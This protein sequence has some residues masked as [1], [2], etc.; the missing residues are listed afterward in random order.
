MLLS[1]MSRVQ[2]D[3]RSLVQVVILVVLAYGF[4]VLDE[5]V[6]RLVAR[7]LA[8]YWDTKIRIAALSVWL[9]SHRID[10]DGIAVETWKHRGFAASGD[11]K[12]AVQISEASVFVDLR[13]AWNRLVFVEGARVRKVRVVL[14]RRTDGTLNVEFF[15]RKKRDNEKQQ[16]RAEDTK[17]GDDDERPEDDHRREAT[18]TTTRRGDQIIH[19]GPDQQPQPA[20]E[21]S[22]S[23]SSTLRR[24][25]ASSPPRQERTD[26]DTDDDWVE[27]ATTPRNDGG[28]SSQ[29]SQQQQDVSSPGGTK[30]KQLWSLL[31]SAASEAEARLR[32][33]NERSVLE[34][35]AL[36]AFDAA[37]RA[38]SEVA[39][40]TDQAKRWARDRARASLGEALKLLFDR[41]ELGV[42]AS[43][44]SIVFA[45]DASLEVDEFVVELLDA[46][47]RD[48]IDPPLVFERRVLTDLFCANGGDEPT[49]VLIRLG[50]LLAQSCVEDLVDRRPDDAA[51]LAKAIAKAIADDTKRAAKTNLA[52]LATQAIDAFNSYG[53][54]SSSSS[55]NNKGTTTTKNDA[56]SPRKK[57]ASV[58]DRAER[59]ATADA[60]FADRPDDDDDSDS[61]DDSAQEWPTSKLT[62]GESF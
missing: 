48:L 34:D 15:A 42:E 57:D 39:V 18:T 30:A 41:A 37:E 59:L 47:G 58:L 44:W 1:V 8:E 54:S 23:K 11:A 62:N 7:L 9:A 61:Y 14:M 17:K 35:A 5:L 38:K 33:A 56:A 31:S 6:R 50:R 32:N 53:S 28:T 12:D 24:F 3:V 13:R 2:N 29:E 25:F 45:T 60:S 20:A 21:P 19:R 52:K 22:S 49:R 40:A 36:Y 43:T 16:R 26:D 27:V 46:E 4:G 10:L 51:R 55:N